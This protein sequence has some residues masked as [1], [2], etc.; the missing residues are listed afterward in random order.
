MK[1]ARLQS[2]AGET[3]TMDMT[4]SQGNSPRRTM[5]R[6]K[7]EIITEI[8]AKAKIEEIVGDY[9]TLKRSGT[10]LSGL[11]P[12]HDERSASF[13]VSPSK[14]IFN[15]FGCSEGGDVISF[16]QKIE[17]IP[18][19]EAIERLGEKIGVQI[20]YTD[21]VRPVGPPP[22]QRAKLV[23]INALATRF[24]INHLASAEGS[25]GREYLLSRGFDAE[26]IAAFEI[27]FSPIAWDALTNALKGRG[28]SEDDIVLAGLARTREGKA[29][30]YDLFR[31]RLMWPIRD[32]SGDVI[33]FGGRKISAEDTG[34]KYLNSP[35]TPLYHKSDVLYGIYSARRHIAS[36]KEAI[37]VEGYTDVMAC[38]LSG[39]MNAVAA[40]GT[41]FGDGHIK[42]L[43]RLLHDVDMFSGKV[44]F[45]FDG[46]SAGQKAALR[47][48]KEN[49]RFTATT[50]VVVAPESMD[51]A[52]IR[53]NKGAQGLRDLMSSAVPLAEFVLKTAI[54]E[55]NLSTIEGR[56]NALRVC[57]PIVAG[58][59]DTSMRI[60]YLTSLG[61]W[62]GIDE[63]HVKTA[64]A[65]AIKDAQVVPIT[66]ADKA[67][68]KPSDAP[69]EPQAGASVENPGLPVS[70]APRA[71]RPKPQDLVYI[72]EREALKCLIQ[73]PNLTQ[74]W[75]QS[76]KASFFSHPLYLEIYQ[77][78]VGDESDDALILSLITELTVEP[79]PIFDVNKINEAYVLGCLN[80]L[81]LKDYERRLTNLKSALARGEGDS[82]ELFGKILA[83][84]QAKRELRE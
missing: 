73:F 49:N 66:T 70:T 74:D 80:R 5:S 58:I 32:L 28:F 60:Q 47:A 40:C 48:F 67:P 46:D 30:V 78:L 57:A 72:A 26:A 15:C 61:G 14:N 77:S 24:F 3:D 45:T 75:A 16:I 10:G 69:V 62:L 79:L 65:S 53:Q 50:Y 39:I 52:E 12:F 17:N 29:G 82:D 33:G 8:R 22:G 9:V 11:C 63:R 7:D 38:H 36:S 81:K 1:G 13:H 84:E 41:A 2:T 51:P 23:E 68:V 55:H 37:L 56:T 64:V 18:F 25:E 83:I 59:R 19:T 71:A 27:G 21:G 44:I 54:A 76:I 31:G 6:I 34:P 42:I 4:N 43:R 20:E 35:E